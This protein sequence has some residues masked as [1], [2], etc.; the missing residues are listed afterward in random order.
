MVTHPDPS[1]KK[2]IRSYLT[3]KKEFTVAP[4]EAVGSRAL[5]E[6]IP[7]DS[8]EFMDMALCEMFFNTGVHVNWGHSENDSS[9]R[10]PDPN[11]KADKPIVNS[12]D[13]DA[14]YKIVN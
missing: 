11:A 7:T 4:T 9:Y 14:K 13:N 5:V 2:K 6:A 8:I 3:S 1:I 10:K 12:V